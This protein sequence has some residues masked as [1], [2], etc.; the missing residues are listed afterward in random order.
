MKGVGGRRCRGAAGADCRAD[1]V[2][3]G[4]VGMLKVE[5]SGAGRSD[6]EDDTGKVCVC[7]CLS[8][9]AAMI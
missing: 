5:K 8:V 2:S 9:A 1:A 7:V 4:S 6:C 3:D